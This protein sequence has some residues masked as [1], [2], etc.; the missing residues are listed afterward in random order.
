M[1]LRHIVIIILRLFSLS[2][3]VQGGLV[4]LASTVQYS[5]AIPDFNQALLA[6]A[7]P[8]VYAVAAAGRWMLAAWIARHVT[9]E[10]DS[11]VNAGAL[12]LYD[13]YC[14][15]F[16]FLGLYFVLSSFA[17]V[18]NA[19]HTYQLVSTMNPPPPFLEKNASF[20]QLTEPV[21]TLVAGS[22]CIIFASRIAR[23]LMSGQR[24]DGV[25]ET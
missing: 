19:V 7:I 6:Y 25:A 2:W 13:L 23:K 4:G 16:V 20:Y 1:L 14:F 12:T 8:L 24:Q 5:H 22:L 3:L 18:L 17:Q 15:A 21:I 9:P 10:P 11:A